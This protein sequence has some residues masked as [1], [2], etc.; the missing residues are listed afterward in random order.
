MAELREGKLPGGALQQKPVV[1]EGVVYDPFDPPKL[2]KRADG[3][4]AWIGGRKL[5]ADES[6]II[7]EQSDSVRQ[8]AKILNAQ[9]AA[10]KY[11]A[12]TNARKRPGR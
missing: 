11:A 8:G 3:T 12:A 6:S 1:I 10:T 9:K 5:E 4:T 2:I 7:D